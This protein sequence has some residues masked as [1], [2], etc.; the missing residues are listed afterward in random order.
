MKY[1]I[2]YTVNQNYIKYLYVSLISLLESN[3]GT[4]LCVHVLSHDLNEQGKKWVSDLAEQYGQTVCF[5]DTFGIDDFKDRVSI[6]YG[7]EVYL[8]LFLPY[9]LKGVSK[10]LFL[11][12]DTVVQGDLSEIFDTDMDGM[13]LAGCL[14][15]QL[16]HNLLKSR[17]DIF[18][19]TD[20]FSY[21]NAGVMLWNLEYIRENI[22]FDDFLRVIELFGNRLF[23][24]DQDILNYLFCGRIMNLGSHRFNYMTDMFK[25]YSDFEEQ[26]GKAA[27]LHYAGCNPWKIGKSGRVDNR[28]WW[29]LAKRT[30][31]YE[32]IVEETLQNVARTIGEA[33]ERNRIY[34]AYSEFK[35]NGRSLKDCEAVKNSRSIVVYGVGAWGRLLIDELGDETGKITHIVDKKTGGGLK[36]MPIEDIDILSTD[37]DIDLVI[38][39]PYRCAREI[40]KELETKVRAPM[41][42]LVELFE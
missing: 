35:L 32:E 30:P 28:I 37:S 11:D 33:A 39:T 42:S 12:A 3:K 13:A 8:R 36:G 40:R 7:V 38:I 20:D 24:N 26:V 29:E 16:G 27:V 10:V 6:G 4:H 41:I 19:R 15:G 31:F 17:N 23:F 22:A 2:A 34:Q 25:D 21:Y 5:H 9:E 14:D 18:G 1:N